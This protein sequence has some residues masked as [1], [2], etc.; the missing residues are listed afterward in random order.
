MKQRKRKKGPLL[1]IGAVLIYFLGLFAGIAAIFA[2]PEYRHKEDMFYEAGNMMDAYISGEEVQLPFTNMLLAVYSADGEILYKT[3]SA[4][5]PLDFDC[6]KYLSPYISKTLN[7]GRYYSTIIMHNGITSIQSVNDS[8]RLGGDIDFVSFAAL[9]IEPGNDSSEVLFLARDL[10]SVSTYILV[11]VIIYTIIIAIIYTTVLI[12]FSREKKFEK[13]QQNYLDNITHDLKSP[14]TSIKALI[15]SLSEHNLSEEE[16]SV[17]Y[18]IILSEIN[19]QE[20]MVQNILSLSKIQNGKMDLTKRNVPADEI[21]VKTIDKYATLCE[22]MG[23]SFHS[24]SLSM[25]PEF[26]TN[27]E[28]MVQVLELLL[29]NAVKFAADN[30]EINLQ[31]SSKG[32]HYIVCVRDNGI[33][34]PKDHL[35]HIF[36]RFYM[37]ETLNNPHGSGLGLAIA[38]EIIEGLGEKIWVNSKEGKGSSFFFTISIAK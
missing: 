27:S 20:A 36:E 35:P 33:G 6:D 32:S 37:G 8:P 18:G 15:M 3:G 12:E 5:H 29:D 25:L 21:F 23:I 31:L 22:D 24:P 10:L 19:R 4:S 14:I 2:I 17:Y 13:I 11:Y 26:H 30:G 28:R 7:S 9:P 38:K 1:I 16:Q 34:I